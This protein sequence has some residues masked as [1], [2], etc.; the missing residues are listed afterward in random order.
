MN[1]AMLG[2]FFPGV[3]WKATLCEVKGMTEWWLP[4]YLISTYIKYLFSVWAIE[5]PFLQ[6]NLKISRAW[7]CVPPE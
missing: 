6:K 3:E 4:E 2:V 7:S 1:L 5:T